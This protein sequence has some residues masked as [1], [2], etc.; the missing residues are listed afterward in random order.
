MLSD[1]GYA[2]VE[3]ASAEET[4]TLIA[5]G[6]APNVVITDHLMPGTDLARVLK[7]RRPGMPVLIISGYAEDDGIAPGLPRLTKPFRQAE[8]AGSRSKLAKAVVH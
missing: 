8:L 6:L 3:T 7:E 5:G 1:L 4:L 2:V